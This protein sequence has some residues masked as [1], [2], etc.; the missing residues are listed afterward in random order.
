LGHNISYAWVKLDMV[1][2]VYGTLLQV[3]MS[4]ALELA[5]IR[6]C[7]KIIWPH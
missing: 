1:S 4:C 6:S 3:N 7:D 5:Q 2:N